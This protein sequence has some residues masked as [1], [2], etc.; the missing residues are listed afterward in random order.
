MI[1]IDNASSIPHEPGI[2]FLFNKDKK[3]VYVGIRALF[4]K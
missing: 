4:N 1:N 3:M 2:Y